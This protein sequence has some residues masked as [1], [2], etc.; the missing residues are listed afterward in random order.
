MWW[1]RKASDFKAEMDAHL[2]LEAD[3]LR[4]EGLSPAESKAAA[5]R[6]LGNRTSAEERFYESGRWMFGEHLL[7]D[8]RFAA[9]LLVKDAKFSILAVLGLGLGIGVSTAIFALIMSTM[10]LE[11]RASLQDPAS[12]VGL[13]NRARD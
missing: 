1:K 13:M 10:R 4:S 3:D 12:Y 9:R 8:L 2:E 11:D 7:R 6:A 5:R